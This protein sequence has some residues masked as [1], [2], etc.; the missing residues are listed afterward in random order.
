MDLGLDGRTAVVSGASSGMGRAIAREL[1]R[2]GARV[3]LIARRADLLDDAVDE[4]GSDRAVAVVGDS[5]D[6]DALNRLVEVAQERFGGIDVVINNTG[7]P[8]AGHFAAL[9]DDDWTAAF[10]LTVLSAVRLTRAALPALRESGS[11]RVVN[12]TGFTVL[13]V[14]PRLLLSSAIRSSVVG[15]ARALAREEAA[16][17]ITINSIAAGFI[18]TDRL[19]YLYSKGPDPEQARQRDI[20]RIPAA[21]MGTAEEIAAAAAFLC[22]T[23]AAYITGETLLVDG[24]LLT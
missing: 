17:G 21:R 19:L 22:S 15:W 12:I 4:L 3:A 24:G 2:E 1:V 8:P 14:E 11:G 7:G 10:E 16:N 6:P 20:M 5:R 23:Q 13:R 18:E 9:A